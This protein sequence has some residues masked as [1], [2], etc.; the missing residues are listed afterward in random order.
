MRG[1]S[2]LAYLG[3]SALAVVGVGCSAQTIVVVPPYP[4][5]DG[6]A[7]GS[8]PGLL[9]NLIGYWRLNDAPASATARDVSGSGNDGTLVGLDPATAWVAGGPEGGSLSAQGNGY[10][11]VP[12]SASIDSITDQVTVAA[13][14]FLQG[15]V[16]DYATAISRQIGNGFGQHYHLSVNAQR[17]AILFIT[18][19][20]AGQVVIGSP[21][22]VPQQA[23]V[24][25]AGTYDGSQIRLYVNGV[26]VNSQPA[27][28]PFAA[29]TNPVILSGNGNG[30][31]YT[32]SEFVPGQLDGIMLYRRALARSKSPSWRAGRCWRRGAS[33]GRR[34]VNGWSLRRKG[35]GASPDSLI[36][37]AVVPVLCLGLTGCL[38]PADRSAG[39]ASSSTQKVPPVE[40]PPLRS[41]AGARRIGAAVE[42]RRLRE[43][44]F[45]GVLAANFSSL[46]P[47]NEMKWVNV[48]PSPGQFSFTPA[49][50]WSR[51]RSRTACGSAATRWSG[52]S[53]SR[54]GSPA[55]PARR[56]APR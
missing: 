4:C 2:S 30:N 21:M 10:V 19:P 23:W 8:G 41:V 46:T 49:T 45:A 14:I 6:G 27:T 11:N 18:T 52:T 24:H 55:S 15:T 28:G 47:E 12:A 20:M 44:A 39:A 48:E 22:T 26:E 13:W 17:Q 32:V 36:I 40:V 38:V 50:R 56:C 5:A 33:S 7:T 35:D 31:A 42:A 29:E 3:A 25:L 53:S 1:F 43:P 16:T 34:T 51:S 9:D 37:G 54:P